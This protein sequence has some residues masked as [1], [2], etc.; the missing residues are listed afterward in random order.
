MINVLGVSLCI[1]WVGAVWYIYFASGET[2][3]TIIWIVFGA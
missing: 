3:N 1:L 2:Q